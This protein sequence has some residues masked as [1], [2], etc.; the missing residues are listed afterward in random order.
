MPGSMDGLK[1]VHAIRHRWPSV[2]FL[3]TSG[4]VMNPEQSMPAAALFLGKPYEPWRIAR[5]LREL[6]A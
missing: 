3:V 1:L 4:Y 6:T 2:K 5:A